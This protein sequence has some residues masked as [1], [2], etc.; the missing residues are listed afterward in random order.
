M[1]TNALLTEFGERELTQEETDVMYD[2]ALVL[3]FL[4][5][6]YDSAFEFL[7]QGASFEFWKQKRKWRGTGDSYGGTER[8]L[9]SNSISGLG[10]S[11]RPE[12]KAILKTLSEAD[13][14]YVYEVAGSITS[15]HFYHDWVSASGIK[16][17]V[18]AQLS[19]DEVSVKLQE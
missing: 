6:K 3:G 1:L 15:A 11:G 7:Q 8:I 19:G 2:T 10:C 12:V 5:A 13:P 9:V 14:H 18:E 17:L 16:A 4:A